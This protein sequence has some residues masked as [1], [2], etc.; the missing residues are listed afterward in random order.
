MSDNNR[1]PEKRIE[2]ERRSVREDLAAKK[3]TK[4]NVRVKV[5]RGNQTEQLLG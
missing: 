3:Q 4:R 1:E 2:E 5:V